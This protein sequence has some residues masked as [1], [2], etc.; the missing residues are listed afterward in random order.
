MVVVIR[1]YYSLVKEDGSLA[2][3][4]VVLFRE[5]GKMVSVKYFVDLS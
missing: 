1:V 5:K 3:K 2:R 4:M